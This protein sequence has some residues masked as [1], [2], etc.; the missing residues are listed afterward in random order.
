MTIVKP[1]LLALICGLLIAVTHVQL[2]H[3]IADNQRYY[4]ER[5]LRE[6]IGDLE[7]QKNND[8]WLIRQ[9]EN[10]LGQL[11]ATTTEQ[12][13]N[14]IIR[15]FVAYT[16]QGEVISVRVTDHQETPGIGDGIELVVSDW[17][18][19]F[20]GRTLTGEHSVMALDGLTGATITSDA[21]KSAVNEVIA[22]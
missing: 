20:E 7:L 17:V 4:E 12:G 16:N 3:T 21:V 6:M 8:G 2:Q 5:V 19:G 10:S 15:L 1:I 18:L 11:S 22:P 14:G 9:G 13:Y